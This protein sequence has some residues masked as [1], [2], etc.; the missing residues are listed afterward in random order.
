MRCLSPTHL[1]VERGARFAQGS[2]VV[3]LGDHRGFLVRL[4]AEPL[5]IVVGTERR[6]CGHGHRSVG[7]EEA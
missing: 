4:A 3:I 5:G 2:G 1:L 7:P 6:L